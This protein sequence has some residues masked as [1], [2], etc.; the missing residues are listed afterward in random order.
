MN[1]EIVKQRYNDS[2]YGDLAQKSLNIVHHLDEELWKQFISNHPQGNIFHTPEMF[3][4][5][6]QAEGF[7]PT[8]WAAISNDGQVE[9]L[10]TPVFV[11]LNNLIRR[12]TTRAISYGS[13]LCTPTDEGQRA[14]SLLLATYAHDNKNIC[15]FTELRNVSD[16]QREQPV[17]QELGFDYEDHLNY[18]IDLGRPSEEIFLDIGSRTRKNIR[19]GLNKAEVNIQEVTHPD[20][21]GVCYDLLRQTYSA[22]RVPLA[23]RSLFNAAFNLLY[24]L[25]MIRFTLA[26]VGDAPAAVS[27]ELLYKDIMYG[28]YG[29][30]DRSF[31]RYVPNE[32]LMWHILKWG[33]DNG[34]RL[35]DFGGAGNPNQK[36]PVRDFKAKFGGKLVCYG[37]N[38]YVHQP[39]LLWLSKQGYQL[40]RHLY[41][42]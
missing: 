13:V 5:F 32:L 12:F 17:L 26:Y 6:N 3:H 39:G 35:Y 15:L 8:L 37:R 14:L 28:W 38:I 21:L 22:A 11:T 24:P 16:M 42:G 4:V 27:V 33:S 7:Q 30:M 23:N 2:L 9:A 18:L 41:I 10:F 25:G 34:Y 20:Q 29:G 31:S 19:H 40:M 1:T 36:Y